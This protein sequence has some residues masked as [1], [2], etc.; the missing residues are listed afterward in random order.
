MRPMTTHT[1]LNTSYSAD[2]ATACT[3][4]TRTMRNALASALAYQAF[5]LHL[6]YPKRG[7]YN[8]LLSS[9]Y[10]NETPI[11]KWSKKVTQWNSKLNGPCYLKH[12]MHKYRVVIANILELFSKGSEVY[13]FIA[14]KHNNTSDILVNSTGLCTY[15]YW[16]AH[17]CALSPSYNSNFDC[18]S[19]YGGKTYTPCQV[20][21]AKS[22]KLKKYTL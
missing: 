2:N 12:F 9:L 1:L 13:K 14:F 7:Y 6:K 15:H 18:D 17:E 22:L 3:T 16:W 11:Y 5:P 4:R 8:F 19:C 10:N 20:A 21:L